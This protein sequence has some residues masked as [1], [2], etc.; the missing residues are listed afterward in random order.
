MYVCRSFDSL[1]NL[2]WFLPVMKNIHGI[3]SEN[4][5]LWKWQQDFPNL[6]C[7][8]V[9]GT[10]NLSLVLT[11][12]KHWPISKIVI[13]FTPRFSSEFLLQDINVI[14]TCISQHLFLYQTPQ[15]KLITVFLSLS[16]TDVSDKYLPF[17]TP[18][19][20]SVMYK[21]RYFVCHTFP[22]IKSIIMLRKLVY[23]CASHRLVRSVC[24][25]PASSLRYLFSN[26]E[27]TTA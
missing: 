14:F 27:L 6:I 18:Y 10:C 11:E 24:K 26:I 22:N 12:F 20:Q 23:I 2:P 17:R 13:A 5:Q 15:Q 9:L 25:T 4:S 8:N 19:V 7:S 3:T 21:G 1:C 16:T